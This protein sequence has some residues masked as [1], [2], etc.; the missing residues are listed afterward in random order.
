MSDNTELNQE[1]VENLSPSEMEAP[2][3]DKDS[4]I[5]DLQKQVDSLRSKASELLSETKQAK[6][7]AREEAEA[8]EKARQEKAKRD[9]DFEQLLKS[10]ESKNKSLEEQLQTLQ[11]RVSSEKIRS[12][13]LRV[14][15]ELADGTN[16]EILS[17]FITKRLKYTDDGIKVLDSNGDLTVSSLEDLKTE[18]QKSEKFKPLLRGIKASGG[19]AQ[20]SGSSASHK[21]REMDRKAFEDMD[22]MQRM[23]FIK[24]GGKI[25]D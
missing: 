13:S 19:S 22:S 20:G 7:K 10:S 2:E 6:Q 17:E 25:Y 9:G 11:N 18:F 8:K 12:E 1:I 24:E 4:L 3:I 23:K 16:A 21:A 15:A 5:K 14:A